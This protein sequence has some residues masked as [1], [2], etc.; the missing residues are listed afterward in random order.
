MANFVVVYGEG[1]SIEAELFFVPQAG[2]PQEL[3]EWVQVFG[4]NDEFEGVNIS[5]TG[6]K[7]L[8]GSEKHVHSKEGSTGH[9]YKCPCASTGVLLS[10]YRSP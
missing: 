1:V 5:Y 7:Q 6:D 9:L 4:V 10:I 2:L 8:R 3:A